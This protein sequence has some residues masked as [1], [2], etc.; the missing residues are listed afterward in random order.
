MSTNDVFLDTRILMH[1]AGGDLRK[2][3]RSERL[4]EAGATLSVQVMNEL[5]LA[6]RREMRMAWNEVHELLGGIRPNCQIVPVTTATHE[7]G[8]LYA[9]RYGL[10]IY[11]AMIVAAAV[12]AG[13]TKL[14]SEAMHEGLVVDG[15]TI[16]NPYAGR[17]P[18]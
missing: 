5:A 18:S 14:Y 13:C 16:R 11:D 7:R 4:V 3:R 9:E 17:S 6:A 10:H 15:L 1:L 2:A 12:L 8:L